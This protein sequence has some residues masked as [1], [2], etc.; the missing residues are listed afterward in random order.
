MFAVLMQR[1]DRQRCRKFEVVP[2]PTIRAGQGGETLV[3]VATAG[4]ERRIG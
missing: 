2:A 3:Q 1:P 4:G